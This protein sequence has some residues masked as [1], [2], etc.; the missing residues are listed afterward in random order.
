[1]GIQP[2]SPKT[3]NALVK[4]DKQKDPKG[5]NRKAAQHPDEQS[6]QWKYSLDHSL[7]VAHQSKGIS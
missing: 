2:F 3:R 7:I 6:P 5:E 1:V 4:L